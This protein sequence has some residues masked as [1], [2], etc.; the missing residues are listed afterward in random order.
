[1]IKRF[2][3]DCAGSCYTVNSGLIPLLNLD[4]LKTA[5]LLTQIYINKLLSLLPHLV[6]ILIIQYRSFFPS[7]KL[8]MLQSWGFIA[9]ILAKQACCCRTISIT[10][11]INRR[12]I[13]V[14]EITTIPSVVPDR[15]PAA[16]V[17]PAPFRMIFVGVHTASLPYSFASWACAT[18]RFMAG[19]IFRHT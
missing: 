17:E 10:I 1:M 8:I 15:R 14:P 12:A 19:F 18:W 13:R 6:F 3:I 5:N 11:L 16:V 7:Y 2:I 4:L 9:T